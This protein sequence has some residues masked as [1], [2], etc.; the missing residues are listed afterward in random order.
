MDRYI[1]FRARSDLFLA[2]QLA[3][4]KRGV[5]VSEVIRNAIDKIVVH[6]VDFRHY[7]RMH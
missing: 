5:S 1:A 2:L 4:A 6:P 7:F 3:A